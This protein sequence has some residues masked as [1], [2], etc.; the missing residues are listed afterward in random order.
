M[1]SEKSEFLRKRLKYEDSFNFSR[2]ENKEIFEEY[3]FENESL[4]I[5]GDNYNKLSEFQKQ[6]K[7]IKNMNYVNLNQEKGIKAFDTDN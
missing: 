4:G 2:K 5:F 1:V 3:P 6:N 7:T